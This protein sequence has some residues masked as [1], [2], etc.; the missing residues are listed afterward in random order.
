ML[1]KFTNSFSHETWYQKYKFKNDNCVED[2]W[3]RVAKDL[4]SVEEN[5]EEWEQKFYEALEDFKFVPGGRITSNAGT[6]L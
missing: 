4:A 5:K 6:G 1:D 2:T 3:K